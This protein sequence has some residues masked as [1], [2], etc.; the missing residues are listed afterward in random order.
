MDNITET[1]KLENEAFKKYC[2]KRM[3]VQKE[4]IKQYYEILTTSAYENREISNSQAFELLNKLQ[5]DMYGKYKF[6]NYGLFMIT[7]I[8]LVI[9]R[10]KG[11]IL[12]ALR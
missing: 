5:F 2:R 4:F 11:R 6:I 8:R 1:I 10:A 12:F 9:I 3:A 7:R